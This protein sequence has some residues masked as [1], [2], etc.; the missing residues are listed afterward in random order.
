MKLISFAVLFFLS[1]FA[2]AEKIDYSAVKESVIQHCKDEPNDNLR[3]NCLVDSAF[4]LVEFESAFENGEKQLI[5]IC[6]NLT[7]SLIKQKT[8]MFHLMRCVAEQRVLEEA[9]PH[10]KYARIMLRKSEFRPYWVSQCSKNKNQL[11]DC[12]KSRESA[13]L[14]FWQFYVS[15]IE[16]NH[17]NNIFQRIDNCFGQGDI[18]KVN[19]QYLKTCIGY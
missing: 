1:L 10:P 15:L 3:M 5:T 18:R 17:D 19:F 11:S 13:L 9:H 14:S 2:H 4:Y 7:S 8:R 16:N 6:A 12:I